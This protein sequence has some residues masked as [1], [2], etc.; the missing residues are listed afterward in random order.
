MSDWSAIVEQHG[1]LVWQTAYRLLNH[2][3]DTADCFQR[4]FLSALELSRKEPIRSWPGAL[5]RLATARAL[6]RLRQRGRE[7]NRLSVLTE[8][9]PADS[10]AVDPGKNAQTVELADDLRAALAEIDEPQAEV[11]CL[12]CLEDASYHEVA[13]QLGI[14]VNHVGVLLHRAKA[15]LR[16]KLV[17]HAPDTLHLEREMPS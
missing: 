10:K 15:S 12:V 5:K 16:Q 4:T 17:G 2:D 14:T 6:E 11:F 1:P 8:E 7:R 9:P 13:G 3:A